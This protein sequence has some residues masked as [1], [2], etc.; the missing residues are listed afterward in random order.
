MTTRI[1]KNNCATNAP[2]S[3]TP[4]RR[5][6]STAS[7]SE[8]FQP[9][10]S[11]ASCGKL[12]AKPSKKEG[13]LYVFFLRI[14]NTTIIE[15]PPT[16]SPYVES[17]L[18]KAKALWGARDDDS[19]QEACYIV[20][21]FLRLDFDSSRLANKAKAL[22]FKRII[23]GPSDKIDVHQLD[24]SQGLVPKVMYLTAEMSLDITR[25]LTDREDLVTWQ[26]ENGSLVPGLGLFFLHGACPDAPGFYSR[27]F[28]ETEYSIEE[29]GYQLIRMQLKTAIEFEP[30][31]Q[32]EE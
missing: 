16:L 32:P 26:A 6:S 7:L 22:F 28:D 3:S 1:T 31:A 10:Q 9:E 19:Q 24:F 14:L 23:A 12:T 15:Q 8:L 20:R 21:Q 17:E 11:T 2:R 13:H 27:T 5:D 25:K 18:L 29:D 4:R 30:D